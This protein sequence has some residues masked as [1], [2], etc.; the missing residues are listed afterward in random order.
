MSIE[1]VTPVFEHHPAFEEPA[2]DAALWRYMD[3]T[4]F[5]ALLERQALFFSA[6]SGFS[7]RFEASLTPA[8]KKQLEERGERMVADWLA[9][10]HLTFVNCWNEDPHENVALWSAYSSTAGGVAIKS[11]LA[12]VI[13]ALDP[14]QSDLDPADALHAGRVRYIDYTTAT[15]PIE[16]AFGPLLHKRLAYKFEHEVRLAL[17][18]QRLLRAGGERDPEAG[19][20]AAVPLAPKGYDVGLD[21]DRL[22]ECVVLAPEAPEWLL[23]LVT[24]VAARYEL[25]CPVARSDLDAEPTR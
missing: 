17:W 25:T 18:P 23:D 22:I 12:R 13:D 11:S 2:R 24:H 5:V 21:P 10:P 4:R 19:T 6:I 7:D 15:I 9:W 16:N 14:D 3:F 20:S 1:R 8:L